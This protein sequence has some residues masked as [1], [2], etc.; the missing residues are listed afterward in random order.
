[1]WD[2]F[3]PIDTIHQVQDVKEPNAEN[4]RAYAKLLPV[5]EAVGRNQA[6]VGDR[7]AA[8]EAQAA[9]GET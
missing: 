4:Q 6:A 2:D 3:S 5:F 8:L 9:G 1:M 7:F